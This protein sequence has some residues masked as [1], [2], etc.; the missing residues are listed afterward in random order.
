MAR[1]MINSG[2]IDIYNT[3]SYEEIRLWREEELSIL[4]ADQNKL[5]D[6]HEL[7]LQAVIE[8]AKTS[9]EWARG[10]ILAPFAFFQMGSG[11][12]LEQ[13]LVSDQDHGIIYWGNEEEAAYF[14]ALGEEITRGLE[15]A[16]YP[17]CEGNVMSDHQ[18][19]CKSS[20]AWRKQVDDWIEENTWSSL[21][22]LIIFADSRISFGSD[23][24]LNDLKTYVFSFMEPGSL[25][26]KRSIENTKHRMKGKSIIGTIY[27]EQYGEL[28][29]MFNFKESVLYPVVHAA[30]LWSLRDNVLK[31]STVERLNHTAQFHSGSLEIPDWFTEA[32]NIRLIYA[33]PSDT[34]Q[35]VHYIQPER[36]SK[37]H[38]KWIKKWMKEGELFMRKTERVLM[39][40]RKKGREK[41]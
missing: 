9:V 14:L 18:L 31:A 25:L 22:N 35:T 11:G 32:L 8:R 17:R 29:G 40:E 37:H 39:D 26:L 6:V 23:W 12:R 28:Q 34:V 2:S 4:P 7:I 20:E 27:T 13:S 41:E 1:N 5:N 21:R 36:L 3:S 19:W 15:I 10:A 33:D 16:G 30:R 38:K 24:L